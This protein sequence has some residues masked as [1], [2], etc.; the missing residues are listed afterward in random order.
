MLC[1]LDNDD[2]ARTRYRFS[3]R[4]VVCPRTYEDSVGRRSR[5]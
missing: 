2:N 4:T 5:R 1:V 3:M